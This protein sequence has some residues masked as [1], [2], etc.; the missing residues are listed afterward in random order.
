[1]AKKI[2]AKQIAGILATAPGDAVLYETQKSFPT[3]KESGT[4]AAATTSSGT[5]EVKDRYLLRRDKFIR[6][7]CTF[8]GILFVRGK[9]PATRNGDVRLFN[10]TD[11]VELGTIHFTETTY[12]LKSVVLTSLPSSG[13][14]II[15]FDMRMNTAGSLDVDLAVAEFRA[16]VT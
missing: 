4:V 1:M 5:Y 13:D 15:T 12:T 14:K 9:V 7:D 2:E 8:A 6:V 10:E 3:P 11:S 16:E